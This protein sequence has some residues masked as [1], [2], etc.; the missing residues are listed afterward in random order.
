MDQDRASAI[1]PVCEAILTLHASAEISSF[2]RDLLTPSELTAIAE[3]WRIAE[4]LDGGEMS[5][6]NIAEATGASTTTIAR[7]AR[8]L[9]DEPHQ[10][11][12][13]A[14]DRRKARLTNHVDESAMK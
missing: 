7:V 12:R 1:L 11:Y 14:L 13:M 9:K 6:R 3:R 8:F 4:L 5:Y 2:L 10:G